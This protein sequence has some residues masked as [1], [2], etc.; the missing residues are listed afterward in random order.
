MDNH[1]L[2]L[3]MLSHLTGG[4]AASEVEAEVLAQQKAFT[5]EFA[6]LLDAGADPN[7]LARAMLIVG[8][9]ALFYVNGPM[10]AAENLQAAAEWFT[11]LAAEKPQGGHH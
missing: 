9:S 11:A 1:D 7:D 4:H 6:R 3:L 8:A 10:S 5:D 2:R